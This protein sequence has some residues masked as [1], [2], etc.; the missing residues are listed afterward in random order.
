MFGVLY[1][2][3]LRLKLGSNIRPHNRSRTNTEHRAKQR[4]P[5]RPQ[6]ENEGKHKHQKRFPKSRLRVAFIIDI[7]Q[8]CEK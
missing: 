8:H 1:P 3:T 6:E 2:T 4:S 7:E 5:R